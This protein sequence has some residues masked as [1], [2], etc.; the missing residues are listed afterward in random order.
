MLVALGENLFW[1]VWNGLDCCIVVYRLNNMILLEMSLTLFFS[2]IESGTLE[3]ILI[4]QANRVN[5]NLLSENSQEIDWFVDF[6]SGR[7]YRLSRYRVHSWHP[8]SF[9]FFSFSTVAPHLCDCWHF[10]MQKGGA[11]SLK[12]LLYNCIT[13]SNLCSH[14]IWNIYVRR[15]QIIFINL[16]DENPNWQ[17]RRVVGVLCFT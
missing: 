4:P 13:F 14:K 6:I 15:G 8:V 9:L 17:K 16:I 10:T 12:V 5:S 1:F 3:I 11:I 7:M 2:E